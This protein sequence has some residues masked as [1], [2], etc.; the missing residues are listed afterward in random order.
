MQDGEKT[1]QYLRC[2]LTDDEVRAKAD[3]LVQTYGELEQ[4][5]QQKA[6]AAADFGA[7]IKTA[8]ERISELA[9]A[10]RER[11]EYRNVECV[12]DFDFKAEAVLTIRADTGETVNKRPMLPEERQL[13]ILPRTDDASGEA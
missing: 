13:R 8:R 12:L 6:A 4:V 5:E 2:K 3:I 7:Q 9:R 10:V 11:A 1:T